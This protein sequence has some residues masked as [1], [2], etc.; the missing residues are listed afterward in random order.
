MK[1]VVE[2]RSPRMGNP[3]RC[4]N[5]I[6]PPQRGEEAGDFGDGPWAISASIATGPMVSR[7]GTGVLARQ[8]SLDEKACAVTGSSP[9]ARC[10][11]LLAHSW[12]VGRTVRTTCW[13]C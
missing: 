5:A 11:D 13:G 7:S 4:A 8:R 3:A 12:L 2:N 10:A 1:V 9:E 6:R